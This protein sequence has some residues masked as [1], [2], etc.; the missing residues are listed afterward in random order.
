M[1]EASLPVA[2]ALITKSEKYLDKKSGKERRRSAVSKNEHYRT[3]LRA[4]IANQITFRYVLNDAWFASAD[5]MKLIKKELGRE[6]VMP[7]KSNRLVALSEQLKGEGIYQ[8][9]NTLRLE[10]GQAVKV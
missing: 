3:L 7:L 4:C 2:F 5:N 10:P 9:V 6:F 1:V 8:A